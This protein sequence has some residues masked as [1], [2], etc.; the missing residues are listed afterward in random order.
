MKRL[1]YVLG[2]AA[3]T[4]ISLSFLGEAA[5]RFDQ[6]LSAVPP[7]IH[8]TANRRNVPAIRQDMNRKKTAAVY[9]TLC[10]LGQS[11]QAVK[12]ARNQALPGFGPAKISTG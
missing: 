8:Y 5:G 6:R 7:N 10:I 9:A 4:A 11:I 12:S 1:G 3:L 2:L